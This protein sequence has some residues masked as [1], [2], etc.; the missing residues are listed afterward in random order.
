MRRLRD[1]RGLLAIP[2]A[3]T[4]VG[5]LFVFPAVRPDCVSLEVSSS[6]EPGKLEALEAIVADYN[7]A[8]RRVGGECIEASVHGTSSGRATAAL[9]EGWDRSDETD[10]PEPQVWLPTSSMWV[11]LLR[12][13]GEVT[14]LPSETEIRSITRSLLV[15]ALPQPM[16]EAL[17]AEGEV[18]WQDVIDLSNEGWESL[19]HPEWGD[20]G[21]GKD[22]PTHSTSGLAATVAAYYAATGLSSDLRPEDVSN[23]DHLR[24][25]QR[26]EAGVHHYAP[27][28][29]DFLRNLAR[30]DLEEDDPLGY[31]S[32][33]VLQE[34]L[35]YEYNEGAYS[36]D[37]E[38]DPA[39]PLIPV[40][41]TDGTLPL[42]HPYVVLPSASA[43]QRQAAA[44]F[45][46]YL[47]EDRAQDRLVDAGFR[48]WD[49]DAAGGEGA[50]VLNRDVAETIDSHPIR[51]D[52]LVTPP[53]GDVVQEIVS[54][55]S[56]LRK[57][58][59][60]LLVLDRSGSMHTATADGRSRLAVMQDAVAA[61]LRH[62]PDGHQVGL[63]AFPGTGVASHDEL[64]PL[65]PLRTGRDDIE[66]AVGTIEPAG[67]TPLYRT[68]GE[69]YAAMAREAAGGTINAIVVL[70]DGIDHDPDDPYDLRTLLDDVDAVSHER[71]HERSVRVFSIAFSQD[72][73][74]ATM[75]EISSRTRAS[76]Y[77][78]HDTSALEDVF[79]DV[80]SNF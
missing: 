79:V 58:A 49:E 72:A 4:V 29:I 51:D 27:D 14:G 34:Q 1:A 67:R 36:P 10:A 50:W 54:R 60:V 7:D 78:A 77:D 23:A 17:R 5:L 30:Y 64:V 12:H 59:N 31:V 39:T 48:R 42:D 55:W 33:V 75:Q 37:G 20:F 38:Q 63:W 70:T 24:F 13:Q 69:A 9:G 53:S 18:T 16:A 74:F 57:S 32:A 2:V 25:V 11:D 65:Q 26:I 3:V 28:I 52:Q 15:V 41:P 46:T 43:V 68:V 73:E 62:L 22:D 76:A 40:Y 19:G 71:A 66:R 44:D 61:S 21:F 35:V 47:L 6:I 56:Q 8:D 45:R 80:V